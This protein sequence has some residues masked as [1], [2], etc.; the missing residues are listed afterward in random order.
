MTSADEAFAGL[1]NLRSLRL[2]RGLGRLEA[3]DLIAGTCLE[4]VWLPSTLSY[5][6]RGLLQACDTLR[7]VHLPEGVEV[8]EEGWFQESSI[9]SVAIPQSVREIQCHAFYGCAF[10]ERVEFA[11]KSRL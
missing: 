5:L 4:E 2:G 6:E 11:E 3:P 7:V 10:L 9:T 1:Q 8:I